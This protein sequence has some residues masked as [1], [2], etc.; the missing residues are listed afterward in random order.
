[1]S[2]VGLKKLYFHKRSSMSSNSWLKL[3]NLGWKKEINSSN[4][5]LIYRRPNGKIVSQRRHLAENEKHDI[6][7]ILF[8]RPCDS[9]SPLVPP[10]TVNEPGQGVS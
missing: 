1:M 2:F 9:V 10:V 6:G 7:D 8:S 5:R 4:N 3:K